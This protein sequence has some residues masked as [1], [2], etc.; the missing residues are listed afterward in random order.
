MINN[1]TNTNLI[2]IDENNRKLL[3]AIWKQE[4]LRQ[5]QSWD[6]ECA[7]EIIRIMDERENIASDHN[8]A[9]VK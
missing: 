4:M 8:N 5:W 1:L 9:S 3:L 7:D 6:E 2:I